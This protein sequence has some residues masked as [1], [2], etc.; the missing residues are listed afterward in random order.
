M[1][2]IAKSLE[3]GNVVRSRAKGVRKR[4]ENEAMLAG[5]VG[6]SQA[7]RAERDQSAVQ[8][9]VVRLLKPRL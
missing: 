4:F 3:V 5:R 6:C 8:D 7:F 1:A 2:K 9:R